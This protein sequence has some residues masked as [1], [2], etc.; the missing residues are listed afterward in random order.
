[1]R[2]FR[3]YHRTLSII[4]ALPLTL[5]IVT[6]MAVTMVAEWR[7]NLGLSRSLLLRIHNGEIFGLQAFY[8]VLNGIGLLALLVTGLSMSGLFGRRGARSQGS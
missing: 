6:G 3:K 2:L 8:P 5:T 4:L 7:L 1:M